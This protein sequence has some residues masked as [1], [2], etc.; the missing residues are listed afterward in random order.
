MRKSGVGLLVLGLSAGLPSFAQEASQEPEQGAA[1]RDQR[2]HIQVLK[3]PYDLA[4]FYRSSGGARG[5]S[6]GFSYDSDDYGPAAANDSGLPP[7]WFR[8]DHRGR[9]LGPSWNS[10]FGAG[11]GEGW[12][13]DARS[14][15]RSNSRAPRPAPRP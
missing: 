14:S 4:S 5:F 13:A 12:R 10:G 8:P 2:P 11:W 3:H 9:F 6:Y 1:A 7:T 15:R